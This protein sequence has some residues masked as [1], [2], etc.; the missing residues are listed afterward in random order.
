MAARMIAELVRIVQNQ[1][2][3]EHGD[4]PAER[5]EHALLA[6]LVSLRGSERRDRC[7]VGQSDRRRREELAGEHEEQEDHEDL[8]HN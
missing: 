7:L 5:S 8:S 4:G 6:V 1:A 3:R 2:H